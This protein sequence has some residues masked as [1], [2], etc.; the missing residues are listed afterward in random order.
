ME[1]ANRIGKS[2]VEGINWWYYPEHKNHD[3]KLPPVRRRTGLK[4][5]IR[6]LRQMTKAI[7]LTDCN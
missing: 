6:R 3:I 7:A 4:G 2:I 1:Q 5:V